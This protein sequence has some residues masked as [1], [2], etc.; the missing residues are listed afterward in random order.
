MDEFPKL[1]NSNFPDVVEAAKATKKAADAIAVNADKWGQVA[2][3]IL[4]WDL[5]VAF[6]LGAFAMLMLVNLFQRRSES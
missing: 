4:S 5:P 2:D 1:P 6:A 3:S